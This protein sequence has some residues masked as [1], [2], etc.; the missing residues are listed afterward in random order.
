MSKADGEKCYLIYNLQFRAG[1]QPGF[2]IQVP[3]FLRGNFEDCKDHNVSA[4]DK[5]SAWV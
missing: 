3:G 5:Q 2:R 1:W 4:E